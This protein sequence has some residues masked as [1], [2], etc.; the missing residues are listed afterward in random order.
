MAVGTLAAQPPLVSRAL[1]SDGSGRGGS[2]HA[3]S[4]VTSSEQSAEQ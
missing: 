2:L 1:N 4:A 3:R